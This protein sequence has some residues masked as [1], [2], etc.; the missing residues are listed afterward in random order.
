MRENTFALFKITIY[1]FSSKF[2]D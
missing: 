2:G 1:N